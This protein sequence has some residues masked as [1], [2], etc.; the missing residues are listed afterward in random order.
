MIST[1]INASR[2]PRISFKTAVMTHESVDD[3][4]GIPGIPL[5]LPYGIPGK[6][7]KI[8]FNLVTIR[9]EFQFKQQPV[10]GSLGD[11]YIDRLHVVIL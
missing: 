10:H 4:T 6:F 5:L 8:T 11:I 3:S 1:I 7:F 2:I 9:S